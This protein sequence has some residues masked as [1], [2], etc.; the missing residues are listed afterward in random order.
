MKCRVELNR[1]QRDKLAK[2]WSEM[3][4]HLSAEETKAIPPDLFFLRLIFLWSFFFNLINQEIYIVSEDLQKVLSKMQTEKVCRQT[5]M[6]SFQP[7]QTDV[8]MLPEEYL[9]HYFEDLLWFWH[10][11]K[12][13]MTSAACYCWL[14]CTEVT[15]WVRK[16]CC[17][18]CFRC[19]GGINHII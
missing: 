2:L 12:L 10:C 16:N 7:P 4:N 9:H 8:T 13:H 3:I 18:C 5:I 14:S 1:A 15:V 6:S 11:C 17:R 19:M